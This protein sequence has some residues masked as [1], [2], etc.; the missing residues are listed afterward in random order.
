[1]V[2]VYNFPGLSYLAMQLM[3][4]F[5]SIYCDEIVMQNAMKSDDMLTLTLACFMIVMVWLLDLSV[6]RESHRMMNSKR[7]HVIC[8]YTRLLSFHQRNRRRGCKDDQPSGNETCR[9]CWESNMLLALGF[10]PVGCWSADSANCSMRIYK[11]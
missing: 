4:E 1:M 6:P 2:V 7:W 11:E 10:Q 3:Q 9:R 5:L 8:S